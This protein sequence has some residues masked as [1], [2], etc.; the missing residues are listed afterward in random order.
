MGSIG[1]FFMRK[2]KKMKTETKQ[3]HFCDIMCV[4]GGVWTVKNEVF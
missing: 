4:K 2:F 1:P 3:K